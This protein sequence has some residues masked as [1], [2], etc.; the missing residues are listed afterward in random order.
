[1]ALTA[2]LLGRVLAGQEGSPASHFAV[3]SWHPPSPVVL[4]LVG[5]GAALVKGGAAAASA[6][7]QSRLAQNVTNV[8]RLSVAK[9]LLRTG[10]SVPSSELT[11]RFAVRMSEVECG[12]RD[13][14]LGGVRALLQLLPLV[15]G[16][17]VVSPRLAV[18]ALVLLGP[19]A[20]VTSMTRHLWRSAHDRAQQAAEAAHQQ[21]EDLV[22]NIDLWR[23]FGASA[24]ILSALRERGGRAAAL[25]STVEGA[26]A[27]LSGANEALGA[28][29]LALAIWASS[30]VDP[31]VPAG[32]LVVFAAVFFMMY[33]PLRDLGE[34]RLALVAGAAAMDALS[35][36][37]QDSPSMTSEERRTWAPGRLVVDRVGVLRDEASL[38]TT[39]FTVDAGEIV[40]LVGPTGSG[41]TTLLRAL[42]GLEPHVQGRVT[43]ASLDISHAPV[44]PAFRPFAWAPQDPAILFGSLAENLDIA[45]PDGPGPGAANDATVLEVLGLLGAARLVTSAGA[46]VLGGGGRGVSG[47]EKKWIALGRALA[48]RQPVLLLDEP[49]AGLDSVARARVLDAIAALRGK[50]SVVLV[51]H[52]REPLQIADRIVSL[53]QP[54]SGGAGDGSTVADKRCAPERST[55]AQSGNCP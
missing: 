7:V 44:G 2:G 11:A 12:V 40:V 20:F 17:V 15:V 42:L 13:G 37:V 30:A 21:V 39:S 5:L 27:A 54:R 50:R 22:Q 26:R 52:E 45:V 33:R 28:A 4:S 10:A 16:L 43:Y 34:A 19:F 6:T 53:G 31:P 29:A 41:K 49:T 14:L 3:G 55:S 18:G 47:G 46:D 25:A 36:A 51:T 23:T 48:S 32:S 38:P 35:G 9:K 24:R 8:L 1:M